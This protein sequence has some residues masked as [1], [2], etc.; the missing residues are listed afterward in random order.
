MCFL[1]SDSLFLR[2]N[3]RLHPGLDHFFKKALFLFVCVYMC[4]Y[5]WLPTEAR[6]RHWLPWSWSYR[7]LWPTGSECWAL[8]AR[9]IST[10][11]KWAISPPSLFYFYC[12]GVGLVHVPQF[13]CG[14]PR[15]PCSLVLSFH[16][17]VSSRDQIHGGKL[18]CKCLTT[19]PFISS[20]R[21]YFKL[22][23]FSNNVMPSSK[24]SL[25]QGIH[26]FPLLEYDAPC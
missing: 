20:W 6:G 16:F 11:N 4:M 14:S 7:D 10:F 1:I 9:A 24:Q 18:S 13:A 5:A 3:R 17:Y 15:K 26:I 23:Y 12:G 21:G 22:R 19:K 25:P 2:N 8:T